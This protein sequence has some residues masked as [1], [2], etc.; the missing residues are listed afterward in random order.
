MCFVSK[1]HLLS[2]RYKAYDDQEGME[3][4]WNEVRLDGV[5]EQTKAKILG[6]ITLLEQLRHQNIMEIFDSWETDDRVVFITEIMYS[7]TL[8]EYVFIFF[9]IQILVLFEK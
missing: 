1:S 3:V 6:E 4:A 8:K 5:S 9:L 7:G 2:F